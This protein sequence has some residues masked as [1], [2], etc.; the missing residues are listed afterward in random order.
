MLF[1]STDMGKFTDCGFMTK[2]LSGAI[3]EGAL[4]KVQQEKVG[5]GFLYDTIRNALVETLE[6]TSFGQKIEG[7]LGEFICPRLGGIQGKMQDATNSM[8]NGALGLT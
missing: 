4:R 3:A 1:R 6:E 8:K 7:M 5:G 2:F